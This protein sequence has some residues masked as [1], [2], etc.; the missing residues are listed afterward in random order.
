MEK[1]KNVELRP[2]DIFVIF[3]ILSSSLTKH[4]S[5]LF[6]ADITAPS[7]DDDVLSRAEDGVTTGSSLTPVVTNVRIFEDVSFRAKCWRHGEE[8][9]HLFLDH[10]NEDSNSL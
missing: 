8:D 4:I 6:P 9:L 5:K 10:L 1:L 7:F 3:D 2:D